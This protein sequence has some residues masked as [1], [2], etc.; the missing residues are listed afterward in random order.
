LFRFVVLLQLSEFDSKWEDNLTLGVRFVDLLSGL[1]N[2]YRLF[3]NN[4]PYITWFGM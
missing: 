4:R 2:D 1:E 3:Q